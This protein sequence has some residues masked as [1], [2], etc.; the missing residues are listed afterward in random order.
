MSHVYQTGLEL[1]YS[2][3]QPRRNVKVWLGEIN[4][5]FKQSFAE[6]LLGVWKTRILLLYKHRVKTVLLRSE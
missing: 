6:L 2:I 4:K 3:M 1:H 5:P